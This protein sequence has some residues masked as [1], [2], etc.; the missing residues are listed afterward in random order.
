MV[1]SM[2][3]HGFT[4]LELLI[5]ISLVSVVLL[6]LSKVMFSLLNIGN[7]K[8]YASSDEITRTE[9]IK[10]IESDF[11]EKDIHGVKILENDDYITINFLYKEEKKNL[12]IKDKELQYGDD[13]YKLESVNATYSSCVNYKYKDLD[14]NYYY[15][16]VEIPVLIDGDNTTK[17]DD[18]SLSFI[19]AKKDNIDYP[20]NY[21]CTKK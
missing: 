13:I 16:N 21:S 14:D 11:L 17:N 1:I 7:D 2:K 15:I 20:E 6:L 10:N 19:G 9:I 3:R 18:I 5:S 12:I 8:T 4:I